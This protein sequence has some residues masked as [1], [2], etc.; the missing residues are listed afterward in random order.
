MTLGSALTL[1]SAGGAAVL[2]TISTAWNGCV[3]AWPIVAS[4]GQAAA[5]VAT[6]RTAV[7]VILVN[8]A[9][10]TGA[11]AGLSRLHVFSEEES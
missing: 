10:A 11:F 5:D 4:L 2:E 6:T 1:L 7:L 9:L 3:A 8:L